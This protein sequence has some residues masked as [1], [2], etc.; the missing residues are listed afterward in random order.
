L[1]FACQRRSNDNER[2]DRHAHRGLSPC[3]FFMLAGLLSRR[4]ERSA[5]NPGR[6][7][8]VA[9]AAP[10]FLP[11]RYS[12]LAAGSGPPDEPARVL[13]RTAPVEEKP[14]AEERLRVWPVSRRVNKTGT[15]D[16][17]PS[18]LDEVAG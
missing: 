17:D 15:G 6:L 14:A 3:R 7:V 12:E 2:D 13:A 5:R 11:P 18:L 9:A 8:I 1:R 4:N 16:D 10:A